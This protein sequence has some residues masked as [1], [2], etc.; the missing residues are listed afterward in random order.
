M[1]KRTVAV[2]DADGHVVEPVG[3]WEM[4]LEPEYKRRRPKL[5]EDSWGTPRMLIDNMLNQ[6]GP[7]YDCGNPDG[8]LVGSGAYRLE[9]ASNPHARIEDMDTD[10]PI[11]IAVLF[12]SL[13]AVAPALWDSKF[14]A[15]LCRAYNNWVADFCAAYPDRLKAVIVPPMNDVH[16]A[17]AEIQRCRN[18][19]SAFVGI[20]IPSNIHGKNLQQP[21]LYPFWQEAQELDLAVCT[22]ISTG[23]N[24]SAAGGDRFNIFFQTH[25]VT[26]PFEAMINVLDF[27]TGGILELFPRLRVAFMESGVG[28]VPYWMERLD[29]HY[30]RRAKE[31]PLCKKRPSEYMKSDQCF[32]SSDPD[33]KTIPVAVEFLGEDRILYASDYPHWDARFPESVNELRKQKLSESAKAK[34]L[35]EN[36]RRLFKLAWQAP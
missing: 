34:I 5:I 12:P 27:V 16:A 31:V 22:H 32:F 8:W 9:G 11:D 14:Q 25:C 13:M 15:A 18:K 29:E 26:F 2:V 1:S 20:V 35:G 23:S 17:I 7:G 4:Y 30:E 36:A 6:K 21:D 28:W 24:V 33:E 10:G 19:S 3:M